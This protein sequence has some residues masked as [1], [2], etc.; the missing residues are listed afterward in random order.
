MIIDRIRKVDIDK[1]RHIV[2][3]ITWR[4]VGSL[5]TMLIGWVVTGS[6]GVG[7]TIGGIETLNKIVL[8]YLHERAWYR[9]NWG[10]KHERKSGNSAETES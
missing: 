10:I 3:A 9:V 8:Y 2:K 6:F 5:D 7:A 4:I 1:K